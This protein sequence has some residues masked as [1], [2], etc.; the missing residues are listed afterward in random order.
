MEVLVECH[1]HILTTEEGE[2][3]FAKLQSHTQT[4][5]LSLWFLYKH[6][7]A[8]LVCTVLI[9]IQVVFF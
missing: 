1:T 2:F 4:F 6:T 9:Q 3:Y 8:A 7:I 5:S